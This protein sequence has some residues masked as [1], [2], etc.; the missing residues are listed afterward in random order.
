MQVSDLLFRP[1]A[2]VRVYEVEQRT[3]EC[4]LLRVAEARFERRIDTS[5]VIVETGD[6]DQIGR[7]GEQ[8]VDLGLGPRAARRVDLGNARE[9]DDH[10]TTRKDDPRKSC[11]RAL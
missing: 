8:S 10:E 6:H 5:E 3:R 7:E 11:G 4:L 1:P 2:I 9:S